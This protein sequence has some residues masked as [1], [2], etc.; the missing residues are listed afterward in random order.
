MVYMIHVDKQKLPQNHT[1]PVLKCMK[2]IFF[3]KFAKMILG[4]KLNLMRVCNHVAYIILLLSSHSDGLR[5]YRSCTFQY[6]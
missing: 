4:T 5:L 3:L 6:H 1:L 2:K